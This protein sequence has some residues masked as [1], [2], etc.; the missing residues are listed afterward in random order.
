MSFEILT[1]VFGENTVSRTQVQ[2]WHNRFKEDREDVNDDSRSH[3]TS[4][5]TTNKNIEAMKKIILDNRRI[6]ISEVADDV[7]ISFGSC[8]SIFTNVLGMKDCSKVA[9]L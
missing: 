1:A 6:T 3:C 2:L 8:Q 7:G 4:E 9:K 5:S